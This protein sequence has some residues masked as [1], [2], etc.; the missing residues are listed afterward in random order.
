M[1][2]KYFKCILTFVLC[3]IAVA[4]CSL[5][6]LTASAS[7]E[8]TITSYEIN[9]VVNENN[10]FDITENITANFNTLRHG[11]FRKIPLENSVVRANGTSSSNR[12]QV[13]NIEVNEEFSVSKEDG[14][15][16]I[17]IGSSSKTV[18]GEH[19]YTVKYTY[20]VGKDPLSYADEFY[21]NLVG[22]EWD[23]SID[24]VKFHITMPKKFDKS[25]LNFSSGALGVVGSKDVIYTVSGNEISGYLKTTLYPNQA[26]TVRLALPEGYFVGASINLFVDFDMRA[27]AVIAFSLLCV[28]ISA[29]LWFKFGKD[30]PIVETVQFYPPDNCNSAE[31]EMLYYGRVKTDGVVSML[32]YLANKGYIKLDE[33]EGDWMNSRH[34]GVKIFKV[35]EYD[36]D[37][38]AERLFLDELFKY[39]RYSSTS[40]RRTMREIQVQ[41]QYDTYRNADENRVG[42]ENAYVYVQVSEL[43]HK[44]YKNIDAVKK[45][46]NSKDITE[47]IFEKS[48]TNKIVWLLIMA[49]SIFILI[50]VLPLWGH[51]INITMLPLLMPVIAFLFFYSTLKKLYRSDKIKL[52]IAAC[53][54]LLLIPWLSIILPYV[55]NKPVYFIMLLIGI[56]CIVAIVILAFKMPKRTSYGRELLGEVK[57]FKRFLETAEKSRLEMLV[58]QNP[59]YFYDVLPYAYALGVSD[60]F[61]K[62]FDGIIT[63]APEWYESFSSFNDRKSVYITLNTV[64][65]EMK[66]FPTPSRSMG[67]YTDS[68]DG[69]GSYGGGSSGGCSGGGSGGGG[70]GSW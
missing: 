28:L 63:D 51:K 16:I 50:S 39:G 14:Y 48:S 56:A 59:R 54:G 62:R 38:E 7:T 18:I 64:F 44:F 46:L 12:A 30:D 68:F 52:L 41:G 67:S 24:N 47:K 17:K 9:M 23:T 53:L 69:G 66:S 58:Q 61:V 29:G 13:T 15:Q 10:T 49:M 11:I 34:R 1:K 40:P 25:S 37:N 32:V 20:N 45:R 65:Y 26:F 21:F 70:G 42:N 43:H 55:N 27:A 33:T 6:E 57:G 22:S 31:A 4:S 19:S 36:G 8:Y 3:V 35:K 60:I 5:F 2:K